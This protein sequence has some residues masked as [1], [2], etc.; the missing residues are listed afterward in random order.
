[1]PEPNEFLVL[2]EQLKK[3][4]SD[5]INILSGFDRV[6]FWLCDIVK[7]NRN[8]TRKSNTFTTLERGTLPEHISYLNGN[9]KHEL[10]RY[11]DDLNWFIALRTA[12]TEF[13]QVV[14]NIRYTGLSQLSCRV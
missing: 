13:F 9:V 12:R 1:M 7:K 2:L 14:L 4:V 6:E 3:T 10:A 8:E 11:V 5:G